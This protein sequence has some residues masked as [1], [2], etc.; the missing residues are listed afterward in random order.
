MSKKGS[1]HQEMIDE[2]KNFIIN[3]GGYSFPKSTSLP[4]GCSRETRL[5]L[6]DIVVLQNKN[7]T[8]VIEPETRT[9]GTTICGKIIL[10]NKVIE[11]MVNDNV[12]SK[13]I[14]PTLV[15]LYHPSN[16]DH[17]INRVRYRVKNADIK[18]GPKKKGKKEAK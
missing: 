4:F 14:K 10:A 12:Q 17:V 9:G 16:P 3:K 18:T 8:H 11:L 6:P 7:I 5:Y 15:F 1:G 2:I 13:N